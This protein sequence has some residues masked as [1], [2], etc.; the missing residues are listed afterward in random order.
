MNAQT[1]KRKSEAL[2]KDEISALKQ[3][4]KGYRTTVECA[5]VIGIHRAVLDRVLIVGSGAPETI[6]K[7]RAAINK[8]ADIDTGG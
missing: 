4:A 3:F 6:E 1:T 7:I 8:P 2:T 5:E